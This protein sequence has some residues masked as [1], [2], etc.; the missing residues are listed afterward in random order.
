[1]RL[2]TN[3]SRKC[4]FLF[5]IILR[6]IDVNKC[7][8]KHIL[9]IKVAGKNRLCPQHKETFR[10]QICLMLTQSQLKR[11]Q[12]EE[13]QGLKCFYDSCSVLMNMIIN[14]VPR[15]FPLPFLGREEERPW[16]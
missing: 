11:K 5:L 15:V 13:V 12:Q 3:A 2:V 6:F 16:E 10:Q 9:T 8:R 4:M 1:M 7:R 14:L